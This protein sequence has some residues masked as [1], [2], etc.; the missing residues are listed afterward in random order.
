MVNIINCNVYFVTMI[1]VTYSFTLKD[2]DLPGIFST[3]ICSN[4]VLRQKLDPL[5]QCKDQTEIKDIHSLCRLHMKLGLCIESKLQDGQ[6]DGQYMKHVF[7][8]KIF[9]QSMS[10]LCRKQPDA[11]GIVQ[12]TKPDIPRHCNTNFENHLLNNNTLNESTTC[13]ITENTLS[14]CY[15]RIYEN[16][17][18]PTVRYFWSKLSV[19]FMATRCSKYGKSK[20][21]KCK[22]I[23]KAF[24]PNPKQQS[25]EECHKSVMTMRQC[26]QLER[27]ASLHDEDILS[28][29][30]FELDRFMRFERFRCDIK[31]E[32]DRNHHCEHP[33]RKK[34]EHCINDIYGNAINN[35]TELLRQ[36]GNVSVNDICSVYDA[37]TRCIED[38]LR[39]CLVNA[40]HLN[41]IFCGSMP[42]SCHCPVNLEAEILAR[43]SRS[44]AQMP[45][46]WLF[47]LCFSAL[48]ANLQLFQC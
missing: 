28:N 6:Y 25:K 19:A 42:T 27:L 15:W 43:S 3:K 8:N 41:A 12:C 7:S 5:C 44:H 30:E 33:H 13:R 37:A 17:C 47:L 16:T 39:H 24:H 40:V 22:E 26:F 14:V 29:M 34:L 48:H 23:R 2:F 45:T 36:G 20:T 1:A 21:D 38:V 32:K 11:S 18:S 9:K 10:H 31:K 35:Q 46:I 4:D